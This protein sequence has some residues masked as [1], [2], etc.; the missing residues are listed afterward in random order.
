MMNVSEPSGSFSYYPL[1]DITLWELAWL[2]GVMVAAPN[3][4]N[5]AALIADLPPEVRRHFRED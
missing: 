2:I 5:M 1:P 4:L 3:T